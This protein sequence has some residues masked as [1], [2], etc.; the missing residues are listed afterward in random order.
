M[1]MVLVAVSAW[2]MY[3][4]N[5]ET[6]QTVE[7]LEAERQELA[8]RKEA[9]ASEAFDISTERG[10]EEEIREKFSVAQ[11]G[12]RV[13]VLVDDE[14]ITGTSTPQK[15]PWWQSVLSFVWPW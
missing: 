14:N 10:L 7:R 9:A 3:Q 13:I 11:E 6:Q 15:Q 2:N 5:R 12:E 8:E 4:T 1:I